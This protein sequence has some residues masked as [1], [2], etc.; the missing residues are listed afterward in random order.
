M[1][2]RIASQIAARDDVGDLAGLVFLGY[3][4][5]PPGDAKKLR[6]AHLPRVRAPMLF[7]QGTRD[8]FGTP[9]EIARV[10]KK[11]PARTEIVPVPDGDHSFAVRKR[12]GVPQEQIYE[13]AMNAIARFIT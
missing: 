11:L 2:G 5:H 8:A 12:A 1:G 7:V 10:T 9:A 3:P 6:T 4:L 13:D